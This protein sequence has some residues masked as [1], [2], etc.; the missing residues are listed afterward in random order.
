M[1]E[2]TSQDQVNFGSYGTCWGFLARP[3]SPPK[4]KLEPVSTYSLTPLRNVYDHQKIL[5]NFVPI[6]NSPK[7]IFVCENVEIL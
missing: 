1:V 2:T 3:Y 4:G 6:E 7:M 5:S